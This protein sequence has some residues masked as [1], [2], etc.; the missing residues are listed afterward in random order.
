MVLS[1]VEIEG[2]GTHDL[3]RRVLR[4]GRTDLPAAYPEDDDPGVLHLGAV[5]D[6]QVVGVATFVP[7]GSGR[8][9]LRGMAVDPA[10]QGQGVGRALLEEGAARLGPLWAH[11]RDAALGFYERLGWVVEGEG[12]VHG[13]M[14]LPHHRVVRP[15]TRK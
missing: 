1:I 14:G 5:D 11:A 10:R 2:A 8:W 9:Q 3:R 4:D 15:E 7:D 13:V 12:Y 6:G